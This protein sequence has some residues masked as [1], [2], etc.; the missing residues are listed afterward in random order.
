MLRSD[1]VMKPEL[2]LVS[3][4][5]ERCWLRIWR[6]SSP[7]SPPSSSTPTKNTGTSSQWRVTEYQHRKATPTPA[8]NAVLMKAL[9]KRSLSLRTFCS[10]DSV[11]PLRSSSNSWKRSRMTWRRP[12]LKIC[13]P[14][15][16][17]TR[18]VTYSCNALASRDSIA[19]ASASA[20]RPSTPA[21]NWSPVLPA[22]PMAYSSMMRPKMMGSI[23]A[24]TWLA[25]AS[26]KA[27]SARPPWG[28]R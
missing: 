11:S 13:V 4:M 18:R 27:S 1:S 2:R 14:S 5:M 26:S 24:S 7:V 12:S 17:T 16:C 9:M 20:S 23:S 10:S 22:R 15:F 19:T 8:A 6:L 3:R 28:R 25:A 21:S